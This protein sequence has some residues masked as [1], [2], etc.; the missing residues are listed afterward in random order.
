MH[1]AVYNVQEA[2]K[3]AGWK[4]PEVQRVT[5]DTPKELLK[6]NV[7]IAPSSA[8]GSPW[9]KKFAP[10]SIGV[11]SGWMQVRGAVCRRNIDG[12]FLILL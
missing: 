11:C 6:G 12:G 3:N 10:Y 9:I 5:L 8:E 7:V 4:L 2:L 1:G